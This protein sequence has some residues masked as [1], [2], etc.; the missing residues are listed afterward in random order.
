MCPSLNL[1]TVSFMSSFCMISFSF[2]FS[3]FH[4]AP[5]LFSLSTGLLSLTFISSCC[6]HIVPF[7][8][9]SNTFTYFAAYLLSN[10]LPPFLFS[11]FIS[12]FISPY[13][14]FNRFPLYSSHHYFLYFLHI[15]FLCFWG[16]FLPFFYKNVSPHR[17]LP[18]FLTSSAGT[19][20]PCALCPVSD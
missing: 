10:Q 6:F 7:P 13:F 16:S 20:Q 15:G 4:W 2:H 9:I 3:I 12:Y 19:S 11:Y 17:L 1:R 8:L 14:L 18:G 5:V